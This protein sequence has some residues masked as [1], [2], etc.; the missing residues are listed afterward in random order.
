[1]KPLVFGA[2]LGVLWLLFGL[3]LAPIAAVL[4]VLVQ[5][6][7]IAFAAGLAVRPLLPGM[8]RWAR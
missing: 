6:V 8:R 3:P 4:P 2:V 7:T 1:M 5:P